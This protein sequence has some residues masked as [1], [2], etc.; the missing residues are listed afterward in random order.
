MPT[1]RNGL[2]V[3]EFNGVIFAFG[4]ED[5]IKTF[6]KNEAYIP[7]EDI[8]YTLQPV[9]VQRQGLFSAVVDN[10]IFVMGGGFAPGASYSSLNH[11]YQNN[12]IP[13]FGAISILI[14]FAALISLIVFSARSRLN[15]MSRL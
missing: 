12:V 8:W 13:E 9:P 1:P 15:I 7:E 2:A 14:L 5:T 3:S 10:T 6:D 4:G 11:A